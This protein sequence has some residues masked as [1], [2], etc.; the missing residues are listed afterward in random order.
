MSGT[1]LD[2]RLVRDYLGELDA[3]MSGWPAAPADELRE[4]VTAHLDDVLPPDAG[5]YEVAAALSRSHS[6]TVPPLPSYPETAAI[7]RLPNRLSRQQLPRLGCICA[8]R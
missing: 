5:D 1:V 2:H 3:A 6:R 8:I 4:Q 7:A